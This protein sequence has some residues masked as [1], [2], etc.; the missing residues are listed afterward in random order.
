[1]IACSCELIAISCE[2]LDMFS[3]VLL[4]LLHVDNHTLPALRTAAVEDFTA[5]GGLAPAEKSVS[6]DTP[7]PA[8]LC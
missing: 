1:M 6:A 8:Q 5:I 4:P 7:T 2:L 3:G